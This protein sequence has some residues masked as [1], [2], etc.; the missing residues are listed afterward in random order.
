M[1]LSLHA[2]L[3]WTGSRA[4]RL[5]ASRIPPCP[6]AVPLLPFALWPAFP[7]A[8]ALVGRD[9]HDDYG[10]SVAVGLAPGR[11]SRLPSVIDVRARRRCPVRPLACGHSAPPARRRVHAPATLARY[12]GGRASDA[13]RGR[14]ACIAGDWGSSNAAFTLARVSRA[15]AVRTFRPLSLLHHAAV[16]LGFRFKVGWATQKPSSSELLPA[17]RG[18]DDRVRRRT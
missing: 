13:L 9:P 14:C 4:G 18:I 15:P 8:T 3:Q 11:Q 5:P 2:A 17:A 1:H 7:T 10:N 12:P 6:P 16:P